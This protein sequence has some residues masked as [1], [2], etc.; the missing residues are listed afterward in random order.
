MVWCK[1]DLQ[2]KQWQEGNEILDFG[3]I[4]CDEQ[5]VSEEPLAKG[6][7]AFLRERM[8]GDEKAFVVSLSGG[9][10]SM[11][12]MTI[13]EHLSPRLNGFRVVA[14]HVDYG[15]RP[16]SEAEADFLQSW[17]QKRGVRFLLRSLRD[18]RRD[19]TPREEYEEQARAVRFEI[20]RRAFAEE[21][22]SAVLVGHHKGDVQENVI[23]NVM[24]GNNILELSGMGS[25]S[26]L[27]L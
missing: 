15:N 11:C 3:P 1:Q 21:G 20:Y 18:M 25:T 8:K 5:G 4:E 14:C 19:N 12:V 2:G 13:L 17:C 23:A 10:D 24:R 27:S 26:A 16:E 22:A 9:V 7:E 6:V